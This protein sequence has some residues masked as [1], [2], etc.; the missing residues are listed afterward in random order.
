MS[1]IIHYLRPTDILEAWQMT[2]YWHVIL[3]VLGTFLFSLT[4][5]S[6]GAFT[7]YRRS[8]NAFLL[9]LIS[10]IQTLLTLAIVGSFHFYQIIPTNSLTPAFILVGATGSL[11]WILVK[12]QQ[13]E[14]LFPT[15]NHLRPAL[16]IGILTLVFFLTQSARYFDLSS[17]QFFIPGYNINHDPITVIGGT[18]II[19]EPQSPQNTVQLSSEEFSQVYPRAVS[20]LLI[21][22]QQVTKLPLTTIYSPLLLL[23]LLPIP[24]A[25]LYII[26]QQTTLLKN[27]IATVI[28]GSFAL[29]SL[30]NYFLISLANA[31]FFAS[32]MVIPL[33]MLGTYS[34]YRLLVSN[35]STRSSKW[36]LGLTFVSA[37]FVYTYAPLLIFILAT[38]ILLLFYRRPS[39]HSS[40]KVVL[41]SLFLSLM[42]PV[43]SATFSQ[44]IGINL[45]RSGTER[46]VFS[47]RGNMPGYVNPLQPLSLWFSHPNYLMGT[48]RTGNLWILLFLVL[49][50]YFLFNQTKPNQT[51]N[52]SHLITYYFVLYAVLLGITLLTRS[53]YQ[54]AKVFQQFSALWPVV[55]ALLLSP[56]L[57]ATHRPTRFKSTIGAFII[58]TVMSG[59]FLLAH[60]FVSR[61][62]VISDQELRELGPSLCAL[63]Q[64]TGLTVISQ[65]EWAR[66][67]LY[68]CNQDPIFPLD[69]TVNP[70]FMLEVGDFNQSTNFVES[71][72]DNALTLPT[73]YTPSSEFVLVDHCFDFIPPTYQHHTE[74]KYFTLYQQL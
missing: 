47:M 51:K 74:F 43:T 40:F 71:C 29:L 2:A 9:P 5:N 35:P 34:L 73:H 31:G 52:H 32:S 59:S 42:L 70:G 22:F 63:T 10:W 24:F 17:Q 3:P 38:I 12:H 23:T 58:I 65:S 33:V 11:G 19:S 49:G 60:A 36:L 14:S 20:Y 4:I 67:A 8:I 54:N 21:L 64:D 46:S 25:A 48:T 56:N 57:T 13:K 1:T 44:V 16:I 37:A 7:L 72:L 62:A 39:W 55:I 41:V 45:A 68:D 53:P 6:W 30:C 50:L 15:I 26:S 66:L 69:R 28:A 18:Q 27:Y 61:P